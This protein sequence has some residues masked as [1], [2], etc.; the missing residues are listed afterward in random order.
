MHLLIKRCKLIALRNELGRFPSRVATYEPVN[1]MSNIRQVMKQLII[2]FITSSLGIFT[3][4]LLLLVI[5][6]RLS[7]RGDDPTERNRLSIQ[8]YL[9]DPKS[10]TI[11]CKAQYYVF[12]SNI[13]WSSDVVP[14]IMIYV[15]MIIRNKW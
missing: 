1:L 12:W 11:Q 9:I 3:S 8:W 6:L 13:K 2:Y 7:Q 5:H 4:L 14:L 15:V 10:E